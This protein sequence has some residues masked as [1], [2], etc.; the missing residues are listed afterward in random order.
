[1]DMNLDEGFALLD[2]MCRAGRTKREVLIQEQR[3]SRTIIG[4]AHKMMY[5]LW[6]L[7]LHPDYIAG[8][9]ERSPHAVRN[10]CYQLDAR[11]RTTRPTP[12]KVQ[13]SFFRSVAWAELDRLRHRGET[14]SSETSASSG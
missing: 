8:I 2:A 3:A 12:L 5:V 9:F 11:S 13:I 10:A 1:M 14:F 4:L 7:G 6:K